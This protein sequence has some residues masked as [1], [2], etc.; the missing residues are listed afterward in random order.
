MN[1]PNNTMNT[2]RN[3][4]SIAAVVL[5]EPVSG[6]LKVPVGREA[7][8]P[9]GVGNDVVEDMVFLVGDRIDAGENCVKIYGPE[10]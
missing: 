3:A 9:L 10:I 4:K 2:I 5:R 1:S 7:N 8:E 6:P